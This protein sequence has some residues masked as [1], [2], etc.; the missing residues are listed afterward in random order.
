MVSDEDI[1]S[2]RNATEKFTTI[3]L[4]DSRQPRFLL[5]LKRAEWKKFAPGLYTGLGGKVELGE[6]ID[7]CA[8]RELKE[9]AGLEV[10][11]THFASIG[12]IANNGVKLIRQYFGIYDFID[13]PS[14]T[15]GVLEKISV[16]RVFER[17]IIPT[18]RTM[19]K[20]WEEYNWDTNK[21]FSVIIYRNTVE[22]M[23]DVPI[24]SEILSKAI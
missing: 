13:I 16:D 7:Q 20:L 1:T 12:V 22:G 24:R 19:L 18:A 8:T 14:C 6:E 2:L 3:F 4:I 15:E 17:E 9:E 10:P 11:L 23:Y 5:M 21:H